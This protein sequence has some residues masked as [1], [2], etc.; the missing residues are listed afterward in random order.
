M[1]VGES[2]KLR[3]H[4]S[5]CNKVANKVLASYNEPRR[6]RGDLFFLLLELEIDLLVSE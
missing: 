2:S 6:T 5:S 3:L 4:I 1:C